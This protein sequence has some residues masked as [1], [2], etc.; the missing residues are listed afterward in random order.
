M[1]HF[2]NVPLNAKLIKIALRRC[3]KQILGEKRKTNAL[4][5]IR[6]TQANASVGSGRDSAFFYLLYNGIC[7]TTAVLQTTPIATAKL[8]TTPIRQ[9]H[10]HQQPERPPKN[11]L[12]TSLIR[13]LQWW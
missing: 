5:M 11:D 3:S 2:R 1:R 4:E 9:H 6:S 13:C 12:N 8:D 10:H 7:A